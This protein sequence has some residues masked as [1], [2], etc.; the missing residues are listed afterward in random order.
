MKISERREWPGGPP[1]FELNLWVPNLVSG[2]EIRIRSDA[3]G[4]SGEDVDFGILVPD[5]HGGPPTYFEIASLTKGI[6]EQF[7]DG[8]PVIFRE[9]KLREHGV[10]EHG[11][12]NWTVAPDFG[13]RLY[14]ACIAV[15][16]DLVGD[17]R[18]RAHGYR[19]SD[20]AVW[21]YLRL[22][23]SIGTYDIASVA[24]DIL[25]GQPQEIEIVHGER[26]Q[27]PQL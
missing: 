18:I 1:L 15:R 19:I 11:S 20:G 14:S 22:A 3:Y 10:G 5:E 17:L 9:P 24:I 7:P 12:G 21:F 8:H 6:I 25:D 23:R 26:G 16:K 4:S 2:R 27:A 13:M